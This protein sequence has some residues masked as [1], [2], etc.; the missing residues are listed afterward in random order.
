MSMKKVTI[1]LMALTIIGVV[2]AGNLLVNGNFEQTPGGTGWTL[3]WGNDY[4]NANRYVTDPIEG[5]HCAGVW[6]HDVGIW[7]D[8]TIGPGIYEFG[9][10]L[11][12]TQGM[13]NRR[14]VIQAEFGGRVQ[15]LDLVPGDA[16]NVWHIA[17][18]QNGFPNSAIIDNT[19]LGATTI[20]IN[21]M[22]A[23]S[24]TPPSGIVFYDNI[25]FGP[26]G[27]SK[28]AKFPNPADGATV[29]PN[30][31][32][33]SWTNPDPN[34]PADTISCKVYLEPYDNDPN[35]HT[36]PIATG[37]TTGTVNLASVGVTLMQSTTYTWRVD[38][39]DPHGDPNTR[40]PVTTQGALWTF[41][42]SNDNPPVANAGADK[43][44][45][46]TMN[47]GTPADGKVTFTLS[48][49]VVDDGKSP[50]TTLWA[51]DTALTQTD[52][53]TIV[54]I[55]NPTALTTTVTIDK[56]GWFFFNLTATDAFASSTD[57]M[58]VGVYVDACEAANADPTDIPIRYPNGN[59]DIN[60]DCHVDLNDFAILAETWIDCMSAKLGCT[61]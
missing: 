18:P 15:Q 40:G 52:P 49:S 20:R 24:G 48:G 51:L 38:C 44:V 34:N 9:G 11:M 46:L 1:F 59:G 53:A 55:T 61:P 5:D 25:Y 33:L 7:Q 29:P 19:T 2:N 16:I 57:T 22:M 58:N 60:G 26:L 35:F 56:T 45:W 27:I 13:V 30:T 12:T 47:D 4:G 3:W 41:T 23:N 21:L 42:T 50:V 31:A 28:Q 39:T 8:V 6:W 54:T 10:K 36:A 32:N 17:S 14:G 43:Y 37:V